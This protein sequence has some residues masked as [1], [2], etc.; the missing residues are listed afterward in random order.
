MRNFARSCVISICDAELS[1]S[2]VRKK[3]TAPGK[4]SREKTSAAAER[5]EE[6]TSSGV[7]KWSVDKEECRRL[8]SY[9]I[10]LISL[11][12]ISENKVYGTNQ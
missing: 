8:L 3:Q 10:P 7:C 11:P 6:T 4:G 5:T 12:A 1:E 2:I 9:S